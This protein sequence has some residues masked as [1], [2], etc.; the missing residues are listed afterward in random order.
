ML[1]GGMR[2]ARLRPEYAAL[3]PAIEPGVWMPASDIGRSLLLWHLTAPTVPDGDRLMCEEHF[4]FRGGAP[5]TDLHGDA[6]TRAA[7]TRWQ[8]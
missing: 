2:E 3:Y 5:R 6:R 1:N 4:E 7:D 8:V